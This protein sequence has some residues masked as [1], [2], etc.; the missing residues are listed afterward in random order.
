MDPEAKHFDFNQNSILICVEVHFG[1]TL[2]S[3]DIFN[4]GG[5][6]PFLY[7][8]TRFLPNVHVQK[9]TKMYKICFFLFGSSLDRF[10]CC[11]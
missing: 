3:L 6:T 4:G 5:P 10:T 2:N 8:A 7:M 11:G 1:K 9:C